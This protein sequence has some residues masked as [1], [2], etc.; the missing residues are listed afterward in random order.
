MIVNLLVTSLDYKMKGL[1]ISFIRRFDEEKFVQLLYSTEMYGYVDKK[2]LSSYFYDIVTTS[3]FAFFNRY[4]SMSYHEYS[5]MEKEIIV[6]YLSKT[7]N[8]IIRDLYE[9]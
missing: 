9:N 4:T 3:I 5:P 7:F 1:P 6:L 2:S 8:K